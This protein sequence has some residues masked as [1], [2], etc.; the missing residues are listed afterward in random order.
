MNTSND[1]KVRMGIDLG[2]TKIELAV[3]DQS[4]NVLFR[5]RIPTE[6]DQG[7]EHI[8][9]QIQQLYFDAR[10]AYPLHSLGIGTPG[11]IS[12]QSGLLRNSNTVCLNGLPLQSLIE[13]ALGCAVTIENDANCFALAEARLGAGQH[14]SCVFGVIMGTGCGGGWV[15]NQQLRRGPQHLAGEWGHMV[16]DPNGLPCFC[17]HNGC[18]ETFISG[19][20]VERHYRSIAKT[21]DNHLSCET[22][23]KLAK[24]GSNLVAADV[25]ERFYEYL[26]QALA[27]LINVMDPDVIVLGGGLSNIDELP[28]QCLKSV[29]RKVFT[30]EFTTP[31]VRHQ[32]GDSAGVIGAALIGATY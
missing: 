22:I 26:G 6:A 12:A 10:T 24:S 21:S 19:S 7:P 5:K 1:S 2:G 15:F 17:G 16:L 8:I 32:L 3:L 31:I 13:K 27:N 18:I 25:V 14:Q 30:K 11:S 29:Q 4:H 23:F 9:A 20:G 28:E